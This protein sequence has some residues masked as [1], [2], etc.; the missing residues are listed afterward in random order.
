MS[1]LIEMPCSDNKMTHTTFC[2]IT[3]WTNSEETIPA[4]YCMTSQP[5]KNA[6]ANVLRETWLIYKHTKLM[7]KID[8]SRVRKH[9]RKFLQ[10]IHQLRSV[11]MEQRKLSDQA[12]TLVDLSK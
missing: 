5:I 12:N 1:T 10:A 11:K 2:F 9:Q 8:H 7:K 3:S 4:R 6:A